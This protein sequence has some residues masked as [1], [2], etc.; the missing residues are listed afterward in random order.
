[1][2]RSRVSYVSAHQAASG[3]ARRRGAPPRHRARTADINRTPIDLGRE[4]FEILTTLASDPTKVF[5]EDKNARRIWGQKSP[6]LRRAPSKATSLAC[7]GACTHLIHNRR[8]AGWA[9]KHP[10]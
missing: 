9:L 1:M 8:G 2:T 7:G 4:E 10:S 5:S 6:L 3:R